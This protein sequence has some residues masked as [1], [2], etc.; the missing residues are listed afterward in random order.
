MKTYIL[1]VLNECYELFEKLIDT[2]PDYALSSIKFEKGIEPVYV[3]REESPGIT[4]VNT[5]IGLQL[6]MD[7][8]TGAYVVNTSQPDFFKMLVPCTVNG[9]YQEWNFDDT[10]RQE[11]TRD[12]ITVVYTLFAVLIAVDSFEMPT[13]G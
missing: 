7:T 2:V 10:N 11:V 4:V 1:E 13:V 5:N 6:T 3:M 12:L 9:V 8:D